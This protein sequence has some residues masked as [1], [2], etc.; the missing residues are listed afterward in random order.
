MHFDA[1]SA[2]NL[3]FGAALALLHLA[4]RILRHNILSHTDNPAMHD[5]VLCTL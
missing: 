1:Q 2:P 4:L 5:I 3:T